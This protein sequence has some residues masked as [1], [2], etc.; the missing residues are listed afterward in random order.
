[1][2]YKE[3]VGVSAAHSFLGRESVAISLQAGVFMEAGGVVGY[4]RRWF[5]PRTSAATM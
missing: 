5:L 3:S 1:M 4:R 2:L